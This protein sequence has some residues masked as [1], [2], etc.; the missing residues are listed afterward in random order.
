MRTIGR[1][2]PEA[3]GPD[4]QTICSY[5]GVQWRRSQL[6][7]DASANLACPDCA[8]GLD[9]VSLT[10]GNARLMRSRQPKTVGPS[11]GN[12]DQFTS[13]PSPGFVNPNGP[14]QP[15]PPPFPA[16]LSGL[17][18]F[19]DASDLGSTV[20]GPPY[21]RVQQITQPYPLSGNWTA[22]GISRPW[23]DNSALDLHAGD[24]SLLLPPPTTA[25]AN[26]CTIALAWQSRGGQATMPLIYATHTAG[27]DLALLMQGFFFLQSPA[28]TGNVPG[29][30]S[31]LPGHLVTE[32]TL[33]L[34]CSPTQYDVRLTI[35]GVATSATIPIAPTVGTLSAFQLGRWTG[36]ANTS[37]A[38]SQYVIYAR[39]LNPAEL[40]GLQ[41]YL[42]SKPVG[43]P[44]V[45]AS[46]VTILGD[47]VGAGWPPNY[48]TALNALSN[49]P[50]V[51]NVAAAGTR[52]TLPEQI[53]SYYVTDALPRYS[54][55]RAKNILVCQGIS[56]NDVAA[57]APSIGASAA[58][59][60]VLAAYFAILDRAKADGF[61]V[62]AC[63]LTPVSTGAAY[64][65]A[66]AIINPTVAANY[67][68]HAHFLADIGRVPGANTPADMTNP[69]VSVDGTHFAPGGYALLDTALIPAL[70]AALA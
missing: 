26:N 53:P 46:T 1:R 30:A 16:T 63:T 49:P 52:T 59:A 32:C 9:I 28:F 38:V 31:P 47:S 33:I 10:E 60:Q 4:R 58:A 11:D 40:S 64:E 56:I 21:G 23:R 55:S 2:W 69:A 57:L 15:T 17:V 24:P 45:G 61:I 39:A 8:P 37:M 67:L 20:A 35:G 6:T 42:L 50:R 44:P 27:T 18:A 48:Q 19:F 65:A 14:P 70:Q 7:R 54:K 36:Y 25:P 3:Q 13:P 22:S 43:N 62:L 66:R 12:F 68:A 34:T 41:G 51:L 29:L 5:C